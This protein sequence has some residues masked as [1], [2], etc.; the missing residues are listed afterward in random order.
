MRVWQAVRDVGMDAAR[1]GDGLGR[2]R[3]CEAYLSPA[4]S[5]L[6]SWEGL[7][8]PGERVGSGGGLPGGG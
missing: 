4:P 1:S 3:G 7:A 6:D 2:R 8:F 5:L